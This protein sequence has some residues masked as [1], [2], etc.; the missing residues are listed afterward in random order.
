MTVS[1]AVRIEA[2]VDEAAARFPHRTALVYGERQ[3][4]Y[5]ELHAEM[6]R[7]AALLIEAELRPGDRSA[8]SETHGVE[9]VS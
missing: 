6:D 2:L 5:A 1:A 4:T 3:W 9:G 8:R 7:R